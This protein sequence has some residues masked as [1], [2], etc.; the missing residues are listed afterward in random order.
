[1]SL[2]QARWNGRHGKI[3]S[4]RCAYCNKEI[5]EQQM[6]ERTAATLKDGEK[7]HLRCYIRRGV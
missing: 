2:T 4:R 6:E 1:M 5:T 7:V 3:G